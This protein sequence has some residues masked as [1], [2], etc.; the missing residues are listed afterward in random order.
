MYVTK[1]ENT[2]MRTKYTTEISTL[3]TSKNASTDDLQEDEL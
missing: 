2:V 1:N 3:S